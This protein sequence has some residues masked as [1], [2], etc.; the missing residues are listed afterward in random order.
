MAKNGINPV[1]I[2]P[3]DFG[4]HLNIN[5]V[6]EMLKH[7]ETSVANARQHRNHTCGTETSY[8]S[9]LKILVET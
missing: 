5:H 2:V 8:R 9:I 6:I 7:P 1:F 4:Q 3:E